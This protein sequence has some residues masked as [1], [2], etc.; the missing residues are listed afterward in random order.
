[1]LNKA[2]GEN[3]ITLNNFNYNNVKEYIFDRD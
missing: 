3:M 1:M 2:H